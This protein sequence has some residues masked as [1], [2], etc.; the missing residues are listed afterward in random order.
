[1]LHACAYIIYVTACLSK[2]N[3]LYTTDF[4]K[5]MVSK[6]FSNAKQGSNFILCTYNTCMK[7]SSHSTDLLSGHREL[8]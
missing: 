6:L 5:L 8:S 1:M 2:I 7:M 4:F 3:P